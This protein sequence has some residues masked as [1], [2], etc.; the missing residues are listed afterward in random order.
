LNEE[1]KPFKIY[2][3]Y[4]AREHAAYEVAKHSIE[5]TSSIPVD[6]VPLKLRSLRKSGVYTRANDTLSS[7]EFTFTRFLIPHLN[8]YQDW[9]LFIDCDFVAL[10]DVADLV[11][12]IKDQYAVMCAHH[13]YTPT[14]ETKMD[15]QAQHQYPRKNWSSMM[16]INCGHP[17]NKVITPDVVNN[18]TKTG[19]YFHRFSWLLDE[20]VG[21]VSHEWNWLVG[22]YK[23]PK[24]GTPKFLHYTEGGP[25]FKEYRNC[26]YNYEWY[27]VRNASL[28]NIL[29]KKNSRIEKLESRVPTIDEVLLTDQKKNLIKTLFKSITDPNEYY[30]KDIQKE[31]SEMVKNEMG[32]KVAAIDSIGGVNYKN[33]GHEYDNFLSSFILGSGGY[34]SNFDREA[35]TDIDI[36]LVIRGLGGGSQK[37]IKH[38]W[39]TSRTFYAIDT[40]YMGNLKNKKWHRVTKNELQNTG[41]LIPRDSKRLDRIGY[42]WVPFTTGKKIMICPPS[43]KVMNLWGQPDPETWTEQVIE[44]LKQYTDRPIEVRMKP[45]RSERVSN[46]SIE[47]ALAEDVHCLITYN[48]IAAT[49]ALLNGKPA[50]ALGPNAAQSLCNTSLSEV[51]NL[52]ILD[53]ATMHRFAC[54]LSYCQFIED[55]MRDGTAWSIINESY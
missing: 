19:A 35:N 55:E 26:E 31:F 29:E 7:T 34:I 42:E 1:I 2:I 10:H 28:Q 48:S 53:K 40:G 8:D 51:E 3:G 20:E 43:N 14:E 5:A 36:A 13:D 11:A 32:N 17:S 6:I 24:D 52:N 38:C 30:Y 15:G 9:A 4:D 44:E 54:H 12:E 33:K 45:T 50:I 22:W 25:W 49:E 21:E 46:K 23:E 47:A 41:P 18:E 37:A 16:L 39:E 27:E